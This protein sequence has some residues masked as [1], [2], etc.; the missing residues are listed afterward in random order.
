[1]YLFIIGNLPSNNTPP[2]QSQ[3]LNTP[4]NTSALAVLSG[5]SADR[6]GIDAQNRRT[7]K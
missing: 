1:M 6:L 7:R 3:P 2:I 4:V 5:L